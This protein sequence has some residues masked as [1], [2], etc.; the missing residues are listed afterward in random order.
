MKAAP[1]CRLDSD[2]V[3]VRVPVVALSSDNSSPATVVADHWEPCRSWAIRTPPPW[4]GAMLA[5]VLVVVESD[6]QRR[7]NSWPTTVQAS[8][9]R[10]VHVAPADQMSSVKNPENVPGFLRSRSTV[11]GVNPPAKCEVSS[12]W[13]TVTSSVEA[14]VGVQVVARCTVVAREAVLSRYPSQSCRVTPRP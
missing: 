2:R 1:L 7:A 11:A 5:N 9:M 6:S 8:P 12:C 10:C 13:L 14:G 4:L 3:A